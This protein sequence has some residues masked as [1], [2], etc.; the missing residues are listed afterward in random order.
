M[1]DLYH[2]PGDTGKPW[3]FNK[4]VEYIGNFPDEIGPVMNHYLKSARATDDEKIWWVFLYSTCYCMGT[5]IVMSRQLDYRSVDER[6]LEQYWIATKP[7][8]IFQ[9]DRRY[10][11][12]MNQFTHMVNEFLTRSDRHLSDYIMKFVKL[13]D[14]KVTYSQLY[15]EI[16]SWRYYGRFGT[17]LFIFNLCKVFPQV[18]IESS[19]YNWKSGSTTTSA[20]FNARYEDEKAAN[21]DAKRLNLTPDDIQMLDASLQLI[22]SALKAYN[23]HKKWNDIYVT[24]DL[25]SFRKLFKGVRYQG[26][27]VDR[28]MEEIQQLQTNFPKLMEIWEVIWNARKEFIDPRYLGE[29]NGWTTIRKNRMRWFLEHGYVGADPQLLW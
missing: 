20:I 29:I 2:I 26:Y 8:L 28:Q 1:M 5:A 13:G 7:K 4:M 16:S 22:S 14:P 19:E 17:I 12:Y 27:Y 23:P 11:K 15:R 6:E 9:S 18:E 10:I 24:S 21:F 3:R 25:C